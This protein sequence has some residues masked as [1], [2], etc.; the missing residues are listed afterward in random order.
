MNRPC[1]TCPLG[2]LL[3]RTGRYVAAVQSYRQALRFRPNFAAT[4]LNLGRAPKESGRLNEAVKAWITLLP[5][6]EGAAK[7]R[8]RADHPGVA[9]LTRPS[10]R[11]HMW[12]SPRSQWE[13][14]TEHLLLLAPG[15]PVAR[16]ELSRA[17][18]T[19]V[20]VGR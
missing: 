15:D 5:T 13:R 1:L 12:G 20:L 3:L 7:R 11:P 17:V 10:A 8:M 18:R 2:T 4:H 9:A 14:D 19:P 16:Q 6:G